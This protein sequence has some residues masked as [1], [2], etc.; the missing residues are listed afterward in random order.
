MIRV[1]PS[2]RKALRPR[3][4]FD[5]PIPDECLEGLNDAGMERSPLFLKQRLGQGQ[6]AG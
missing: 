2:S 3:S 4:H 6:P 1:L 5:H